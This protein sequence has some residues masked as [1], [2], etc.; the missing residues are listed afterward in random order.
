MDEQEDFG[1]LMED[2]DE[3]RVTDDLASTVHDQAVRN[4]SDFLS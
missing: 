1:D 4:T 3:D 2:I